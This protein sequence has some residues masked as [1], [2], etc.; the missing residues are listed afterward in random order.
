[1]RRM[2]ATPWATASSSSV[3]QYMPNRYSNTNVG[4]LAPRFMS[5][6]RSLRT[7]LPR[8]RS[9]TL[10][11]SSSVSSVGIAL[12][13]LVSSMFTLHIC[14]AVRSTIYVRADTFPRGPKTTANGSAS[15]QISAFQQA[16]C[17]NSEP[18]R[19]SPLLCNKNIVQYPKIEESVQTCRISYAVVA[20]TCGA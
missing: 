19:R 3:E 4:T 2:R 16:R 14:E 15:E 9:T 11:S 5:A 8:K 20:R 10:A 6:V 18:H 13:F 1:M 17:I 12:L 7:I